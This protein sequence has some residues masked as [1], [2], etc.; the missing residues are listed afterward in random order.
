[1]GRLGTRKPFNHISLMAVITP[2]DRPKSVHNRC[3]IEVFVASL[4]RHIAFWIFL[5]V[6]GLCHSTES[7]FFPFLLTF[8]YDAIVV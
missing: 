4:C 1:M 5:W 6:W 2:I 7:E 8:L 3:V